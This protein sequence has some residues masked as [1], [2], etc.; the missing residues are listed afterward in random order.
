MKAYIIR[1]LM[2]TVLVLIGASMLVFGIM[3]L[4]PGD[5]I[6]MYISRDE[7]GGRRAEDRHAPARV[8]LG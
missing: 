8:W 7:W 5:P 1:R 6:L 3:R 4:L 2:Q